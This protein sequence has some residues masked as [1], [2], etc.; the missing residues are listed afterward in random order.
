MSLS[1]G[2][3]AGAFIAP[4]ILGLYWKRI[5][6]GVL[7]SMITGLTVNISLFFIVGPK[8]SPLAASLA[9]LVPFVVM[10]L[11]SLFTKPPSQKTLHKAFKNI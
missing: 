8:N 1:W 6:A 7:A 4:Y 9:M 2:S 10:P 5:T 11:V 3:V